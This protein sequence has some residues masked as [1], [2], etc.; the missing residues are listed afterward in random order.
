MPLMGRLLPTRGPY[1]RT[2]DSAELE[3]LR[4]QAMETVVLDGQ[5]VRV[6]VTGHGV[7]IERGSQLFDD[8]C[9]L[10]GEIKP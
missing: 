6:W 5:Q 7:R 4:E 2:R 10:F 1:E 3:R 9:R 8:L